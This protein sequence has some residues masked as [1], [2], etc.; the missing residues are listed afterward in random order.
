MVHGEGE[1]GLPKLGGGDEDQVVE[2]GVGGLPGRVQLAQG[3]QGIADAAQL[4]KHLDHGD[5]E[6]ALAGHALALHLPVHIHRQ[7]R[8]P[9]LDCRMQQRAVRLRASTSTLSQ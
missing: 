6:G 5:V 3:R 8:L 9:A 1:A 7:V 4:D 2:V